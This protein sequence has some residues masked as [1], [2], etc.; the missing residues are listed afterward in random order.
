LVTGKLKFKDHRDK[1]IES[2][3]SLQSI[4]LKPSKAHQMIS[5]SKAASIFGGSTN[6]LGKALSLKTNQVVKLQPEKLILKVQI[7]LIQY[8]RACN[9]YD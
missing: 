3:L 6:S 4:C 5:P 1:C 9:L 2:K 7:L 8:H